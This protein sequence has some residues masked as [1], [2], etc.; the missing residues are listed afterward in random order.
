MPSL[1]VDEPHGLGPQ[2]KSAPGGRRA[3]DRRAGIGAARDAGAASRD[4]L[5]RAAGTTS[6]PLHARRIAAWLDDVAYVRAAEQ[7]RIDAEIRFPRKTRRRGGGARGV[8]GA[9]QV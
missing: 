5:P 9:P 1:T 2:P 3:G 6:Q 7:D 4:L 8:G